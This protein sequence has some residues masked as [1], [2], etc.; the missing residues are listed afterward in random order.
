[1]YAS[2]DSM[3]RRILKILGTKAPFSSENFWLL[4][5]V[6]L[7]FVFDKNCSIMNYLGLKDSSR[8]LQGN[9][10]ISYYFYLYLML[11]VC[12]VKFDVTKNL[13]NF[14][15]LART[16]RG[17]NWPQIPH[18]NFAPRAVASIPSCCLGLRASS[19]TGCFLRNA[20]ID[21]CD[22]SI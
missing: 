5:T 20:S 17:L 11:Y 16:K 9:Y 3:R 15:F 12:A 4:A 7:S 19:C 6:A 13:K 18:P 8:Q 10:A 2:K 1:M 21:E 22:W 14:C